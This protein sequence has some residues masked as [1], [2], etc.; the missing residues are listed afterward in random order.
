[1]YII[2]DSRGCIE[3]VVF[4]CCVDIEG[5]DGNNIVE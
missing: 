5:R 1:M 3:F 4:D 2:F